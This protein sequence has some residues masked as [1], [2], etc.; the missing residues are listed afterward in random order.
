[1]TIQPI[2]N[3]T[4]ALSNLPEV[5]KQ[6]PHLFKNICVNFEP[7]TMKG[8]ISSCKMV[9]QINS[10]FKVNYPKTYSKLLDQIFPHGFRKKS[11]E[12]LSDEMIEL[13]RNTNKLELENFRLDFDHVREEKKFSKEEIA[14]YQRLQFLELKDFLN[15]LIASG[16]FNKINEDKLEKAFSYACMYNHPEMVN[17]FVNSGRYH[18]IS[19]DCLNNA[20]R[21][22]APRDDGST[23]RTLINSD[24]FQEISQ[25][26]LGDALRHASINGHPGVVQAIM[27]SGRAHEISLE[28]FSD[29]LQWAAKNGEPSYEKGANTKTLGILMNFPQF[30]KISSDDL[31]NTLKGAA[32]NWRSNAIQAIVASNRFH[33]I[34]AAQLN[35][36]FYCCMINFAPASAYALITSGRFSEI[37]VDC[38]DKSFSL[39]A[40]RDDGRVIK[41]LV[42]TT[43][44]RKISRKSI[45][46]AFEEAAYN[47]SP[48]PLRA[49][50]HSNRFHEIS[51]EE[52][53]RAVY[54]AAGLGFVNQNVD[55]ENLKLLMNSPKFN[56]IHPNQVGEIFLNAISSEREETINTQHALSLIHI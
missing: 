49:I 38:L 10:D 19:I 27:E 3:Q 45:G 17:L 35:K 4:I 28:T 14:Q 21:L 39:A 50:V 42:E 5:L 30:N 54:R 9:R 12:E 52:F 48:D 15:A 43:Q 53:S 26:S 29:S 47:Q 25:K 41:A 13:C 32:S 36:S 46:K 37:T 40:S 16:K 31:G 22:G 1:M 56:Q 8:F 6:I 11:I 23:I 44:F 34:S 18:D 33:E 20:F 2:V 24:R 7:Q 51:L 55:I